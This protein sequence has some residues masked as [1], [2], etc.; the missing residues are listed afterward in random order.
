[1]ERGIREG[2]ENERKRRLQ[3]VLNGKFCDLVEN[4]YRVIIKADNERAHDAN[5]PFMKATNAIGILG[6]SV[7]E[8]VHRID[9][10]L[11]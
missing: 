3:T 6:C 2:G 1:M 10:C 7:R 9:H 4:R 5:A 8:F 11:R